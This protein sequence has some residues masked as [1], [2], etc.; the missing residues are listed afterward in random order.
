M[1]VPRL[2]HLEGRV[3]PGPQMDGVE[4]VPPSI[5]ERL[6]PR[7]SRL[8]T[9]FSLFNSIFLL[10][11]QSSRLI[12]LQGKN[13]NFYQF[14]DIRKLKVG[15]VGAGALGKFHSKF[16]TLSENADLVGIIS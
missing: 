4:A 11:L 14:M 9:K 5:A 8:I 3:P 10:N 15:V 6:P 2:Q 7:L 16:Y 12:V 1:L 13:Q